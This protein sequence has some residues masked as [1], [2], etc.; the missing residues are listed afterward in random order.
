LKLGL[1]RLGYMGTLP[2]WNSKWRKKF[3]LWP[4]KLDSGQ[5]IFFKRY[6]VKET[7]MQ[8]PYNGTKGYGVEERMSM[9]ERLLKKLEK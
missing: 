6:W 9:Q 1:W 4:T 2:K 7:F 8:N 3:A 5:R